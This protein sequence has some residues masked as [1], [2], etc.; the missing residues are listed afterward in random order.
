[1]EDGEAGCKGACEPGSAGGLPLPGA[2]PQQ[3]PGSLPRYRA[4]PLPSLLGPRRPS[5]P[6]PAG[7]ANQASSRPL[8]SPATWG[9]VTAS[10]LSSTL[11]SDLK[12]TTCKKG[13]EYAGWRG[14]RGPWPRGTGR[15]THVLLPVYQQHHR[16]QA[17]LLVR[18][19]AGS[20]LAQEGVGVVVVTLCGEG[21]RA[22]AQRAGPTSPEPRPHGDS[23]GKAHFST[24][25]A[26]LGTAPGPLFSRASL[27]PAGRA[28]GPQL[29]P[30]TLVRT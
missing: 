22:V 21:S 1:M 16:L 6:H 17:G 20:Q 11:P 28:Q 5:C 10:S 3:R 8:P 30:P 12:A 18:G 27:S 26:T 2:P 13:R 15:G 7:P 4:P 29:H 25:F 14:P 9:R 19:A 24:P 23:E